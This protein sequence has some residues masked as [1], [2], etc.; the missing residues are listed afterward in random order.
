MSA[1]GATNLVPIQ[2]LASLPA[3][4]AKDLLD[5]FT[6]VVTNFAQGR[7]EPAEL[8]GGKLC[9]AAY[10]IC[11]GLCSN[12]MP[13]RAKKPRNLPQACDDLVKNF[14]NAHRSPRILIPKML[15]PLY[16][17]RNNRGVGHAGGEV[18]PNHM[19]AVCVLQ[20]AKWVVAELIRYLNQLP[21]AEASDLVD[22]LVERET[23]LVWK[24]GDQRRVLDTSLSMKDK[25]LVLLH[26][27]A[28]PVAEAD[29]CNWAEHKTA[30]NFRRDVI[31]KAHATKL[32]EYDTQAKT[33][34]ISPLGI[35]Y[36]EDEILAPRL[37]A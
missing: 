12:S 35:T 33:V 22:S 14:P 1:P 26:G 19:D 36:V 13:K 17:V 23:P 28:G 27:C 31:R 34:L 21:V 20:M 4:L 16:E 15:I 5:A 30:A 10:S 24:V 3:G 18:D 9:E 29:L 8:N 11:E 32:V 7:W 2:A 25:A 6:E 37:A